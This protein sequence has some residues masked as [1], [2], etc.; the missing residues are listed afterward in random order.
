MSSLKLKITT[1][2]A[3]LALTVAPVAA[4][5]ASASANKPVVAVT[6]TDTYNQPTAADQS[7]INQAITAWSAGPSPATL[8]L[9]TSCAGYTHCIATTHV[10]IA[11]GVYGV[12]S[13]VGD[14]IRGGCTVRV[15]VWDRKLLAHE[16]GHCLGLEHTT[17]DRKS[18]VYIGNGLPC[19]ATS[20]AGCYIGDNTPDS[21]DYRNA[22]TAWGR[23]S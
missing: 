2:A 17:T 12:A 8:V 3:A 16:W 18:I 20:Q 1:A 13:G 11:D 21:R 4:S 19:D 10:Y 6:I 5:S 23:T 14:A 9:T 22:K 15:A 7:Q